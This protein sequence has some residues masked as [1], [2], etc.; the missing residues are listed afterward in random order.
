M[1]AF[2]DLDDILSQNQSEKNELTD[3]C[4]SNYVFN[5]PEKFKLTTQQAN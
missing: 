2:E 1:D 3:H 5:E 4:F